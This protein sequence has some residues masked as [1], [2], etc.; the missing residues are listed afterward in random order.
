MNTK[1]ISLAFAAA[2]ALLAGCAKSH[3]EEVKLSE[4][5][6]DLE[7]AYVGATET[8]AAIDGTDFPGEGEIGLF[9]FKDEQ[10]ETPYG[11]S[12]YTNVKYSYNSYKDRWAASPSIK[13]GS[14]PGYLYGYYPY[15]SESTDVKE[16]PVASSLNGDDVM[17]AS[18]QVEPIT[19]ET[20]SST[21]IVMSHAL[22]RVS[23]TIKNNGYTGKAELSKIK[24]SGAKIAQEGTLNALDGKITATNSNVT[25]DVPTANQTITATGSTYECLLVPSGEDDNKQTV[26]LTLTIDGEDKTATLSG[27]NGVIIAQGTKSN[28]TIAL[29]D[30]GISVQTVSVKDWNIVEVGGHKVKVKFDERVSGIEEDVW[31][32][33]Y[34]KDGNVVIKSYS[35]NGKKLSFRRNDTGTILGI[36]PQDNI[37]NIVLSEVKQDITVTIDY[38]LNSNPEF[39]T[40]SGHKVSVVLDADTDILKG[41]STDNSGRLVIEAESCS[42]GNPVK[43]IKDGER[44]AGSKIGTLYKFIISDITGDATVTIGYSK[45][46]A[47]IG[48]AQGSVTDKATLKIN[49]DEVE[50]G[51]STSVFEG[52]NVE[53]SAV[54]DDGYC[55]FGWYDNNGQKVSDAESFT[56]SGISSDV[57]YNAEVKARC[58]LTV[59]T[60]PAGA[61]TITADEISIESGRVYSYAQNTQIILTASPATGCSFVK[62]C[63]ADGKTLSTENPYSVTLTSDLTIFAVFEVEGAL[64]GVFSVSGNKKVRFSKGNLWYGKVGDASEATFNFEANQYAV[65]PLTSNEETESHIGHFYWSNDAT[66]ARSLSKYTGSVTENVFFTNDSENQTKPNLGFSV[67]GQ[68]GFWRVLSGGTNGEWKYL[69]DRKGGTLCKPGVKVC[70]SANCLILLP[71]DW[72]WGENSVGDNWQSEYN[73]STT[74]KWSTMEAAGAVCLPAAGSRGGSWGAEVRN[75]GDAGYYWSASP[76]SG[77]DAYEFGFSRSSVSPNDYVDRSWGRS[78]RLVTESK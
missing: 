48:F 10:A 35:S 5:F 38:F 73:E 77:Y 62:W 45:Y 44:I 50:A 76:K 23:I 54:V 30:K 8:K 63:D 29:S 16:I 33:A 4:Q 3:I 66:V 7:L 14:T 9:L 53:Y 51:R 46:T 25:L 22:A 18:K 57:A 68:T 26:T 43:C 12:G 61:S 2:V 6:T 40:I 70:G 71:D 42:Y 27:D 37:Y 67:N 58:R 49:G 31:V 15:N 56:V 21:S 32:M 59:N 1:H 24:F 78:V 39:T 19:D 41:I 65:P 55:V 74:V 75:V 36:A 64:S 28:I 72:K 17:Y 11:E 69:I 47:T 34:E 60:I 20:A 13:V 52:T